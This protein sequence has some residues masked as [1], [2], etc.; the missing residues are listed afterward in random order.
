MHVMVKTRCMIA[1]SAGVCVIASN[2]CMESAESPSN[3]SAPSRHQPE[4]LPAGSTLQPIDLVYICGNKFLATNETLNTVDVTY[5]VAGTDE[6]GQL[7][8]RP[9]VEEEPGYSET[10]LATR[11]RGPVELY[12]NDELVVRRRNEGTGCGAPAMSASA[13]ASVAGAG[14]WTAPFS[15][16]IVALQVTLLPNGKVLTWG[17]DGQPQVWDPKTGSFTQATEPIELFC[18]GHTLLRDGRVLAAG[19]HIST[20][21]GLPNI[22]I[23][24]PASNSWSSAGLMQRGRWY[25]A[26]TMLGN[27]DVVITAGRDQDGQWVGVPEVWSSGGIRRLT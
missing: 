10:E 2:A 6:Q 5:R 13:S 22:S 21:H 20:G 18:A 17:H 26:V 14:S 27:G 12:Q 19:G 3:R 8:L 15:W 24:D 4:F 16:P 11:E 9:G 1:L 23:F 25:P 7:T